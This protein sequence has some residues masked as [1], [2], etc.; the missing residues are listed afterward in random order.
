[1]VLEAKLG[2]LRDRLFVEGKEVPLRRESGGWTYVPG[3]APGEGGRV[4]YDGLRDRI[5]VESPHGNVDIRFRWRQT[6][7]LWRG[8]RYRLGPMVW[9][10]VTVFEGDRPAATGRLT[11][12]GIRLGYVSPELEPIARELVIGLARRVMTIW[13]ASSVAGASH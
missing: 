1:M 11:L 5:R 2:F 3:D 6:S 7:F 8:R 4:R 12:S 10:H 13:M 9:G